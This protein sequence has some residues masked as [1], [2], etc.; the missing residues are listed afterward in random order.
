MRMGNGA[1]DEEILIIKLQDLHA[2]GGQKSSFRFFHTVWPK[3]R[4]KF[5]ANPI[6]KHG[7][8]VREG[9]YFKGISFSPG[10]SI[11]HFCRPRISLQGTYANFYLHSNLPPTGFSVPDDF[12]QS[13]FLLLY[14]HHF[15]C[16]MLSVQL[17]SSVLLGWLLW[18]ACPP[19]DSTSEH[20]TQHSLLSPSYGISME[21]RLLPTFLASFPTIPP[22]LPVLRSAPNLLIASSH[23]ILSFS[24]L[25]P[26][27]IGYLSPIFPSE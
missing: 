10:F 1:R 25:C 17:D 13:L 3:I 12:N 16:K 11:S 26:F 21:S 15:T 2:P 6:C 8:W 23:R 14:L 24:W 9:G 20:L 18:D 5:L 22:M 4:M 7:T 27:S 19:P